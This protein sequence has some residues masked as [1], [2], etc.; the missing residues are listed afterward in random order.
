MIWITGTI[1]IEDRE[2]ELD[3]VRASGPGGQNV[4][5]VATAVKLR[6]DVRASSS[7]PGEVKER[8]KR[9]EDDGRGRRGNRCEAV[10][11]TG[12]QSSGRT[13]SARRIDSPG[14]GEAETTAKDQTDLGL[15]EAAVGRQASPE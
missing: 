10:P 13:R 9:L 1:A 7:L 6:L 4:N 3:F 8:M 11:H 14:G 15:K 2:I 5:K 12:A